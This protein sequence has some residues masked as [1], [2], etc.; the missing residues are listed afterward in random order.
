[1]TAKGTTSTRAARGADELPLWRVWI[2]GHY[3][4]HQG[5]DRDAIYRLFRPRKRATITRVD[6]V[7]KTSEVL[8]EE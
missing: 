2:D 4:L 7:R 5:E 1:M 3:T 8:A 6:R